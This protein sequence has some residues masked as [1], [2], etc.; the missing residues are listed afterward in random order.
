MVSLNI[1]CRCPEEKNLKRCDA[2]TAFFAA[3]SSRTQAYNLRHS[4]GLIQFS[5]TITVHLQLNW[6]SQEFEVL[7]A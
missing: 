4:I 5:R 3:F 2:A 1:L 7:V 6:V